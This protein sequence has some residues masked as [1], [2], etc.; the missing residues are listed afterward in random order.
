MLT[1]YDGEPV[2]G[3][4]FPALIWK[5]FM[6]KALDYLKAEPAYFDS[7]TLP[8]PSPISIV[9]R[10]GRVMRDN[11]LCREAR[12]VYLFEDAR[13]DRTAACKPNEVE[14]PRVIGSTLDAAR[15]RLAA[16]PLKYDVIYK[17]AARGQRLDVVLGQIP[18]KGTLSAHDTV[19]LVLGKPRYGVLPSVVGLPVD[20]AIRKLERLKLHPAV[21][22]GPSGRVIRQAPRGPVAA[23]P[24]MQVRLIV[25]TG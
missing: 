10:G 18:A 11:G 3:G 15:D 25:S 1:E 24:G 12:T 20:R 19:M 7:P 13:I 21:I 6:E 17:P 16:Q 5:S 9:Q 2:A 22:G 23:A 8:Y 14:V 4:T